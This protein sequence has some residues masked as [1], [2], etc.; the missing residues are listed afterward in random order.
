M[1]D[2]PVDFIPDK[3]HALNIALN[4]FATAKDAAL[5]SIPAGTKTLEAQQLDE[6]IRSDKAK[7]LQDA[8]NAQKTARNNAT[9]N[10][11]Y[12]DKLA[13]DNAY[14]NASLA[15]TARSNQVNEFIKTLAQ[16]KKSES[17]DVKID[18]FPTSSTKATNQTTQY[19]DERLDNYIKGLRSR[20]RNASDVLKYVTDT[21]ALAP[22]FKQ[23]V[24]ERLNNYWFVSD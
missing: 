17:S 20:K 15:E 23:A 21:D 14:D 19:T 4:N 12:Y 8:V 1:N 9:N 7:E 10:Q 18:P 16:Q 3:Q 6:T 24:L 2:I 13:A 22:G 11:Y 5:Y